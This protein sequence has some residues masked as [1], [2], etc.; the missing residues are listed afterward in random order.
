[1]MALKTAWPK[2]IN[3]QAQQQVLKHSAP[4]YLTDS[5]TDFATAGEKRD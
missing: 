3:I 5:L 2:F 4:K 1:M